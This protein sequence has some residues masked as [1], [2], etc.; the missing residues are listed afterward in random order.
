SV[1]PA[2]ATHRLAKLRASCPRI[3][4][5]RGHLGIAAAYRPL[6]AHRRTSDRRTPRSPPRAA[7][8]RFPAARL[9]IQPFRRLGNRPP[10]V[11]GSIGGRGIPTRWPDLREGLHPTPKATLVYL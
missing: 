4:A 2:H 9:S 5:S 11:I 7:S 6:A 8:R 1:S 3:A 10:P